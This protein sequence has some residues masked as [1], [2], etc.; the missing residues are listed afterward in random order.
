VNLAVDKSSWGVVVVGFDRGQGPCNPRFSRSGKLFKGRP[1]VGKTYSIDETSRRPDSG[2]DN[3]LRI[4][5]TVKVTSAKK[6]KFKGTFTSQRS[7]RD[8][9][10]TPCQRTF[11][12][13]AARNE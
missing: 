3:Q 2:V 5:G 8:N 7:F 12:L 9:V 1:K 11:D 13:N 4:T 10:F 6:A